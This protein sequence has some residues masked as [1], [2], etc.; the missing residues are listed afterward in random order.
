MARGL[1][2]K[3]IGGLTVNSFRAAL[4]R[5]SWASLSLAFLAGLLLIPVTTVFAESNSEPT[6]IKFRL[7]GGS[8]DHGSAS[9][10]IPVYVEGQGPYPFLLDTGSMRTMISKDLA[11]KLDIEES[12][13]EDGYSAHGNIPMTLGWVKSIQVADAKEKYLK[14]GISEALD[15]MLSGALGESIGGTI[16]F[17]FLQNY[18]VTLDFKDTLVH[19]RRVDVEEEASSVSGQGSV[20]IR[21]ADPPQNPIILVPVTING[22]GPYTFI[23]DTGASLSLISPD[24]AREHGI[25][26]GER[27]PVPNQPDARFGFIPSIE[28]G[29]E[30]V[31]D[32]R[33][34][35]ADLLDPISRA[36]GEDLHGIIGYNFICKFRVVLDYPNLDLKLSSGSPSKS[37]ASSRY[38]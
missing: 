19:L 29:D 16:G 31:E 12:E 21:L 15:E 10:L 9:I 28:L 23:L 11:K 38:Q 2:I 25:K 4:I 32:L 1:F 33:I 14:V 5:L 18:E 24:L 22:E 26:P 3:G 7:A 34:V 30:S 13:P 6:A 20:P 35:I 17:N 8:A 36:L 27:A 37:L